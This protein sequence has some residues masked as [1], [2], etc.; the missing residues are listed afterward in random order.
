VIPHAAVGFTGDNSEAPAV[1]VWAA[2]G[3]ITSTQGY[4]NNVVGQGM[5]RQWK[6]S[7]VCHGGICASWLT[8]QM[9]A[10]MPLAARLVLARDGWHATFP[11]RTYE[12]RQLD[13]QMITWQQ[14]STWVLRFADHGTTAIAH[15]LN[16]S[17]A[18]A[19]GWGTDTV[20]WSAGLSRMPWQGANTTS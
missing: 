7:R 10:A 6:T 2:G 3:T 16:V 13:G 14:H 5:F 8:R 9:A 18:P 15:E 12:C 11:D 19:C 1:G 17:Y 20:T 4:G